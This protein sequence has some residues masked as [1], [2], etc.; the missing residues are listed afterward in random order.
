M[1]VS[2][3]WARKLVFFSF[4]RTFGTLAK[5][6]WCNYQYWE[7]KCTNTWNE[8]YFD[9]YV[10]FY[11]LVPYRLQQLTNIICWSIEVRRSNPTWQT[12]SKTIQ[13]TKC[14]HSW[15][16]LPDNQHTKT[17]LAH[18]YFMIALC[19][20]FPLPSKWSLLGCVC[21]LPN[22]SLCPFCGVI[23]H[24]ALSFVIVNV[25]TMNHATIRHL[26]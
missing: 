18:L 26:T 6:Q 14:R 24:K 4:C 15:S 22:C 1:Y 5:W 7:H 19:L 23:I 25:L 3:F 21:F 2:Y 11:I 9:I 10:Y 13:P 17:V 8:G 16:D 12:W 20:I